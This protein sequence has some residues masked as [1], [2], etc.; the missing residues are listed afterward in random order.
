MQCDSSINEACEM[1]GAFEL[2]EEVINSVFGMGSYIFLCGAL[3]M[4]RM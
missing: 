4:Q 3:L 1:V 2:V